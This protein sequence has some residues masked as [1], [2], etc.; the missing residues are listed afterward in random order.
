[1]VFLLVLIIPVLKISKNYKLMATIGA[2]PK[3]EIYKV[4]VRWHWNHE[5]DKEWQA[6]DKREP[7]KKID[8]SEPA[9]KPTQHGFAVNLEN[10]KDFLELDFAEILLNTFVDK[11][12]I[13]KTIEGLVSHL[14][15][16]KEEMVPL[17]FQEYQKTSKKEMA[18]SILVSA[19]DYLDQ[20]PDVDFTIL[21]RELPVIM[22]LLY[23]KNQ[24]YLGLF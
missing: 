4:H 20:H 1:M 11:N 16:H 2:D 3:S 6:K 10:L 23:L 24:G 22:S 8:D 18:K 5:N 19:S 17:L 13:K 14:C 21:T 15:S 12:T 9:W 7:H